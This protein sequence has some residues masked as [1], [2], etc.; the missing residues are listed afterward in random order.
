MAASTTPIYSREGDIQGGV[1]LTTAMTNAYT[2]QDINCYNVFLADSTNGG[3]L[4]RLRFKAA[5]TNVATVARLFLVEGDTTNGT[6]SHLASA[7]SAVAGTPTGTASTTGGTLQSGNYYAKIQALDQYNAGTAMSTETAA[8]AVTG[9]T[10]SITW[11]WTAVT[12]AKS[13]RIFVGSATNSQIVYFTSTTNSFTQTA[14]YVVD[15]YGMPAEFLTNT[16]LLGEVALPS[17]T[18]IAT[19]ATSDIDYPLNIALPPAHGIF[20]GLATTVAAGWYVT[21]YGGKY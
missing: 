14:P 8:V 19:T 1:L 4:Q 18:A 6:Y 7:V 9:P 12:G 20:V 21:S 15:Q 3:F 10:G 11:N 17:I 16:T 5:G 2:G 13:Y